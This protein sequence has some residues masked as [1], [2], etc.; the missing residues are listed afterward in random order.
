MFKYTT[1]SRCSL[2]QALL[3]SAAAAALAETYK[4]ANHGCIY[5]SLHKDCQN[6]DP[7]QKLRRKSA[8]HPHPQD[9]M[10]SKTSLRPRHNKLEPLTICR[11]RKGKRKGL[12]WPQTQRERER[13]THTHTHR[14]ARTTTECRNSS[15]APRHGEPAAIVV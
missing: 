2:D 7:K 9:K 14:G 8:N 11:Q 6:K 1:K 10:I 12:D 5:I 15:Q 3:E 4:Q 13:N